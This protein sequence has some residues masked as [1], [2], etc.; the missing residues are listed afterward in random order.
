MFSHSLKDG[1]V[2][3]VPVQPQLVLLGF[4]WL[5]ALHLWVLS[6]GLPSVLQNEIKLSFASE[7][8][9][10]TP[11]PMLCSASSRL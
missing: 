10:S 8:T 11:N 6:F 5:F 1:E 9:S 2:R 3:P 7:C 4:G